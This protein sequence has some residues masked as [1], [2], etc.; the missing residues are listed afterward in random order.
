MSIIDIAKDLEY[1]SEK[2]LVEELQ[3]PSG[4]YPRY[5]VLSELEGRKKL[6]QAFRARE[7][8]MTQPQTTL[9]DETVQQTMGVAPLAANESSQSNAMA[10]APS[11]PVQKF[12]TGGFTGLDDYNRQ[13]QL[14]LLQQ[15]MLDQ[16]EAEEEEKN[17]GFFEATGDFLSDRYLGRG[18]GGLGTALL[19]AS[20]LIPG[21]GLLGLAGRYGLRQLGRIAPNLT[22]K[23]VSA[24]KDYL[25]NPFTKPGG[26][27]AVDKARKAAAEKII[28]QRS[29]LGPSRPNTL[30]PMGEAGLPIQVGRTFSAPRT[31][32]TAFALGQ[33]ANAF[34]DDSV[35]RK[36]EERKP[37]EYIPP[38]EQVAKGGIS[39]NDLIRLGGT[40][41]ASPNATS[42]GT[43]LQNF[44]AAKEAGQ[45]ASSEADLRE[46]QAGYYR[47]QAAFEPIARLNETYKQLVAQLKNLTESG[48]TDPAT[49]SA[50]TNQIRNVESQLLSMQGIASNRQT[51]PM[52]SLISK[53]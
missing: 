25:R 52:Y 50:L 10:A 30:I 20:V 17:R 1:F 7:A 36:K 49:L 35:P 42:L 4:S 31:L 3:N 15:E 21:A 51:N 24:T 34:R 38:Q 32:G 14:Y 27:E 8:A 12:N 41:L 23:A 45:A 44:V 9:A 18:I 33:V 5:I 13:Y 40:L 37:F 29:R 46:A 48:V 28:Q 19:D 6:N 47:K 39:G 16:E 43:G 26:P 11:M 53:T 22:G 2:D